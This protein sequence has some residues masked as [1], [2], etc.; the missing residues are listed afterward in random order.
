ML[1]PTRL[2][3][4]NTIAR[5]GASISF[6]L[7]GNFS[8][9]PPTLQPVSVFSIIQFHFFVCISLNLNSGFLGMTPVSDCVHCLSVWK[10]CDDLFRVLSLRISLQG[11]PV[12]QAK[13]TQIRLTDCLY[14]Q[15]LA[16]EIIE[17]DA[18][19]CT[20]TQKSTAIL[21]F[22]ILVQDFLTGNYNVT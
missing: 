2:K 14:S 11:Q 19:I 15:I 13:Q 8:S 22:T 10:S 17:W 3:Q 12:R 1:R 18:K 9:S 16:S 5:I 20:H 7:L 21:E 6:V 4:L